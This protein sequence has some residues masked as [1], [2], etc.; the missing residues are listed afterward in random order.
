MR[1][2]NVMVS[3]DFGAA[4]ADR[5]QLAAGLAERLGSKLTGVA[6]RPI[7]G[8]I[9]VGDVLEAERSWAAEE[10]LAEED[11]A[12]AKALFEREAAAAQA[13]AWKSATGS[14]LA[15]LVAQ[16]RTA[17]LVVVGREGPGDGDPGV[18]GVSA[19]TLLMEVGRPVL[20]TPPGIEHLAAKKIVVA[21]KDTREARRAVHDAL[22]FLTRA[23]EVHIAVVGPA[24]DQEGAEDVAAYLSGH[25]VTVTTHLL[26]SPEIS[27][28]D[29]I[30]R[31]ARREEAD[32]VVLGAYGHSRL[33]EWIFG[34]VTR[35]ILQTTP[36][37]CLMSH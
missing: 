33:R 29:E 34:G 9:P 31:F 15:Y 8:P 28:A 21:W 13:K 19:G 10:R 23:D 18:M 36:L 22:P 16:A 32:L 12:A 3:V 2:S 25:C 11:L 27:A 1:I 6:G 26:R 4:A 35:D 7:L 5:V 24:A 17:D 37:C 14:P 30:L 20:V